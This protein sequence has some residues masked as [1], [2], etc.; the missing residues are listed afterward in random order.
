MVL[1]RALGWLLLM[2]AVA[3]I[4]YDGLS[5]W[6]AGAFHLAP[7]GEWWSRLDLGSYVAAEK[8]LPSEFWQ[9]VVRPVLETPALSVFVVL[10]LLLLWLGQPRSRAPEPVGFVLGGSRPPRRRRRGGSLS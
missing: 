8:G 1:V 4:V 7:L 6:S 3:A 10:G 5:W 9:W 2:L